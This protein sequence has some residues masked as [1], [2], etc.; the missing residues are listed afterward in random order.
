MYG[1]IPDLVV[2]AHSE[3]LALALHMKGLEMTQVN[4]CQ[5]PRLSGIKEN[6]E[7]QGSIQTQFGFEAKV[8][9]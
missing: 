6:R 9:C 7:Y 1:D 8:S 5:G 2:P 4:F 3:D